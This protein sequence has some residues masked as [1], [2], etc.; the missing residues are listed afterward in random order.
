[1]KKY[2][3]DDVIAK[4]STC[5]WK[6]ISKETYRTYLYLHKKGIIHFKIH[7]PVALDIRKSGGH[8]V[9]VAEGKAYYIKPGW[10][11]I[12]WENEPDVSRAQW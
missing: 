7:N 4:D 6:D 8:I 9:A 3:F 1:M 10:D 5:D 2:T 11:I 12:E